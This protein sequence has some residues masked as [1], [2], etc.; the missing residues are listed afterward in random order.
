MNLNRLKGKVGEWLRGGPQGDVVIS[1]RVRLARNVAGHPFVP[2]ASEQEIRRIEALLSKKIASAHIEPKLTYHR[3]D[4]MDR[5]LIEVLVERHLISHDHA[6]ADWVRGVAFDAAERVSVMVNEEDHLRMQV[7]RGGLRVG[8]VWEQV[9][10]LDDRLAEQIPFAFSCKYGYLTACPT[11]AGTGMRASVMLHLPALIISREMDKVISMVHQR[12]LAVRG[13][14]GEGT[15]GSGDFYQLSNQVTLGVTEEQIVAEV[16]RTASQ[17]ATLEREARQSLL[18]KHRTELQ[19]RLNRAL[20]FLLSASMISSEEALHFLSQVRLGVT[21]NVI[22]DV[23]LEKLNEVFLLT[24]P[25]HLQTM[26]GRSME[27]LQRNELRA[28]YVKERLAEA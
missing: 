1:S 23:R 13:L 7:V 22:K 20:E 10:K 12:R 27:S 16:T 21:M 4:G 19:G 8:K 17:L 25:G 11:N 3:L 5:T 28:R 14:F 18:D 15:Q 2:R 26:E 6:E 9:D 24:L